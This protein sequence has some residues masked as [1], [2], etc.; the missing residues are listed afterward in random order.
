MISYV[1]QRIAESLS[2]FVERTNDVDYL[3][4][5]IEILIRGFIK[6]LILLVSAFL[7]DLLLPMIIV[8]STFIFFRFLT[9]GHHYSTYVRCLFIDLIIM[10]TISY[11]ATKLAL[12]NSSIILA[13]LCFSIVVGLFLSYKYAPSN[14]FYKKIT[15]QHK[16]KLKKY[17]LFSIIIWGLVMFYLISN[18][19]SKELIFA[20]M[21]S[22]LLQ[23]SSIHPYSYILVNRLEKMLE[24]RENY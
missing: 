22:F 12:L 10:L 4:Y 17:S 6:I 3:R 7:L 9:G 20:S 18:S 19:Y 14:H 21:L 1:S 2:V 15:E 13:L 8:L 16:S 5:G 24:R 23:L 11:I